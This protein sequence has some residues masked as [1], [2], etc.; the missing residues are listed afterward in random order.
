V[1]SSQ[2]IS[3]PYSKPTSSKND[4]E[5]RKIEQLLDATNGS[6]YL[7]HVCFAIGVVAAVTIMMLWGK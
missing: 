7:T 1:G 5:S 4:P 2:G 3:V 6:F